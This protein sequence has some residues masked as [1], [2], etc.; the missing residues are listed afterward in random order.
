[1]S[2]VNILPVKPTFV[3]LEQKFATRILDKASFSD[4]TF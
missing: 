1:M 4:Y 2:N 3:K